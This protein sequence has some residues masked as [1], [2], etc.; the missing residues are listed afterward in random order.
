MDLVKRIQLLSPTTLHAIS[1]IN[2]IPLQALVDGAKNCLIEIPQHHTAKMEANEEDIRQDMI[3]MSPTSIGTPRFYKYGP[4]PLAYGSFPQTKFVSP[5]GS[6]FPGD[7]DPMDCLCISDAVPAPST[8][9]VVQVKPLCSIPLVDCGESDWKCVAVDIDHKLARLMDDTEDVEAL[10][11]GLLNRLKR[12]F[13]HYKVAEGKGLNSL[14]GAIR[15]RLE[16]ERALE[17]AHKA[18]EER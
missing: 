4:I 16:T 1:P 17:A 5:R 8:G 12:W 15:G 18:W 3:N 6:A 13:V 14:E 11:P 9:D 7:A 10:F 2:D